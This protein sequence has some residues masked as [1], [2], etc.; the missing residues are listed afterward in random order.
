MEVDMGRSELITDM[1]LVHR[2][3]N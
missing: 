1:Q 2:S 3:V